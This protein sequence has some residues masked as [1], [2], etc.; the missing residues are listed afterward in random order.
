MDASDITL[1]TPVDIAASLRAAALLSL[2]NKRRKLSTPEP[3]AKLPGDISQ[4]A[5]IPLSSQG[6][7]A[8]TEREE[9][10]ISDDE[11]EESHPVAVPA[12]VT[13]S[14]SD[15]P[16]SPTSPTKDRTNMSL[17]EEQ[18]T[19]SNP[20][21]LVQPSPPPPPVTPPKGIPSTTTAAQHPFSTAAARAKLNMSSEEIHEAKVLMLDVLG[22]GVPP[23]YLLDLGLSP[24]CIA[25]CFM[26]LRLRLPDSIAGLIED[27]LSTP[28]SCA[29]IGHHQPPPPG[30]PSPSEPKS[31]VPLVEALPVHSVTPARHPPV[32]PPAADRSPRH[33]PYASPSPIGHQRPPVDLHEIETLRK[34]ELLARRAAIQSR[35]RKQAAA[36]ASRPPAPS[37]EELEM[38]IAD[39]IRTNGNSEVY[40]TPVDDRDAMDVD[41]AFLQ[42]PDAME[43]DELV[44]EE[45]HPPEDHSVPHNGTSKTPSIA[46][47]PPSD[48]PAVDTFLES[49][50]GGSPSYHASSIVPT[51]NLALDHKS[52]GKRG[53]KRPVAA[54]FVDSDDSPSR[55]ASTGPV[56]GR[57][58]LPLPF[59]L[60]KRHRSFVPEMP[61]RIIIDVSEDEDYG[62]LEETMGGISAA[63]PDAR[64]GFD[65]SGGATPDKK[66]ELERK[67]LEI[68]RM[69]E[70]INEIE[71]KKKKLNG[72]I[73]ASALDSGASTPQ[74]TLSSEALRSTPPIIPSAIV[75]VK[76]EPLP[77]TLQSV[78]TDTEVDTPIA[79]SRSTLPI[80]GSVATGP[81]FT[82]ERPERH[83][84]ENVEDAEDLEQCG[85]VFFPVYR[86]TAYIL[87]PRACHDFW[88]LLR[89]FIC[90][91]LFSYTEGC[92]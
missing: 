83:D 31:P 3:G 36:V 79:T 87:T 47:V 84:S 82:I 30:S 86:P 78:I 38:L 71:R 72:A 73:V 67:E 9:G 33:S 49:Q 48:A 24:L 85:G 54:D 59:P 40:D 43:V 16:T 46:P 70:R 41:L 20:A 68:R 92:W 26:E 35:S 66:A 81:E 4:E 10:E 29:L 15:Q 56:A 88:K 6:E 51:R 18:P 1:D 89:A 90:T 7:E 74:A 91:C 53:T 11:Q 76:Q 65:T 8:H 45:K 34:Q 32:T 25:V 80:E 62:D 69:M 61:K 27:V 64:S 52:F 23:Q 42:S 55:P 39:A 57:P 13:P 5:G 50:S 63:E 44:V 28:G 77:S 17:S 12:I 37:E 75:G 2:K 19:T 21:T 58:P 60:I 22:W 14:K